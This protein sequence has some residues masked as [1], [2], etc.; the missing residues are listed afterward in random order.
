MRASEINVDPAVVLVVDDDP[1]ILKT[2]SRVLRRVGHEVISVQDGEQALAMIEAHSV[3][4]VISDINMPTLDGLTLIDGIARID[5]TILTILVTGNPTMDLAL[6]AV[7]KHAYAFLPKPFKPARLRSTVA[8]AVSKVRSKRADRGL[9]ST[10]ELEIREAAEA[11][12]NLGREF[13]D[14]LAQLVMHYQP[15]V[16]PAQRK[17][18]S[19]GACLCKGVWGFICQILWR[20][21]EWLFHKTLQDFAICFK[22]L[23]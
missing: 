19:C 17:I 16:D 8:E 10:I 3:D 22:T 5:D 1:V 18:G 7:E 4:V 14:A 23:R 9:V 21:Y 11:Q 2:F 20:Y 6:A 13:S 15:I 12:E